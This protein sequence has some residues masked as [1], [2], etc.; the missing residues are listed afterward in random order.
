MEIKCTIQFKTQTAHGSGEGVVL[1]ENGEFVVRNKGIATRML[2]GALGAALAKGKEVMR[3]PVSEISSYETFRKMLANYMR[4]TLK[5][6]SVLLFNYSKNVEE[7]L[8]AIVSS[9]PHSV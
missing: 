7:E 8:L 3:F 1:F 5:D 4:F 6:G 9:V 2:F